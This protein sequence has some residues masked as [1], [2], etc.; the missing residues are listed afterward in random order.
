VKEGEKLKA[1]SSNP[2]A[3]R[4]DSGMILITALFM[5]ASLI[6]VVMICTYPLAHERL[7]EVKHH[8]SLERWEMMERGAFG[9]LAHQ[10]GG[11][12]NAC[13]GYFSD[14]GAKVRTK[15]QGAAGHMLEYWWFRRSKNTEACTHKFRYDKNKGFWVGY[16]GK[17]YIV[18]P[19]GEEHMR[20]ARPDQGKLSWREPIL[21]DGYQNQIDYMGYGSA[22]VHFSNPGGTAGEQGHPKRQYNPMDKL[23]VTIYPLRAVG[24]LSTKLIFAKQTNEGDPYRVVEERGDSDGP[25][26]F[27]FEWKNPDPVCPGHT[28]QI[29]LSKLVIYEDNQAR[30]TQ[31][32]CI[33]P[34]RKFR[35]DGIPTGKIYKNVYRINVD[36][37]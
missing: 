28:F 37:E 36:Y 10:P 2:N 34:A 19:P 25:H 22:R 11:K 9:R 27:V 16:R 29:G 24:R 35:G 32:I 13:G 5:L 17:H 20:S 14:T 26:T 8:A 6:G 12:F 7:D 3:G 4:P 21:V 31:A 18:P 30:L 23:V 15:Q 1:Q 33:P